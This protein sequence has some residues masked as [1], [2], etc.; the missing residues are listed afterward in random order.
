MIDK[1]YSW[2]PLIGA[3]LPKSGLPYPTFRQI[4]LDFHTSPL[5]EDIGKKFSK[6]H[7]VGMLKNDA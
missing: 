7:F 2:K 3:D 5:I 1:G 6:D 4:N